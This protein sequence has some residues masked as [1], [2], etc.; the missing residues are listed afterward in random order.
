[1][2]LCGDSMIF[3]TLTR[4]IPAGPMVFDWLGKHRVSWRVYA[5]RISFLMLYEGWLKKVLGPK[6]R[7]TSRL[8]LDFMEEPDS[9]FP[10]VIVVDQPAQIFGGYEYGRLVRWGPVSTGRKETPTPPGNFNL[11]WRSRSR[12]STD[13]DQWLLE[14][15]FNF[16]NA[17]GVSFHQFD[18]PGV[19]ASHACVRLLKRD[20]M[21]L[22]D[23][24]EQWV[25]SPDRKRV[26]TTGTPVVVQGV[27]DFKNPTPW[28]TPA[29]WNQ[30]LTID[31]LPAR[32]SAV[33]LLR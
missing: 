22:Y 5:E 11:T 6:F 31:P 33:P 27:V 8:G 30:H 25:L 29:W 7:S 14:W 2:A 3:E 20:A 10:K 21:W 13:N 9:T 12:R 15:Y 26:E 4:P 1:M 28:T 17:R 24:G 18:L 16:I 19:A 23:W 32:V